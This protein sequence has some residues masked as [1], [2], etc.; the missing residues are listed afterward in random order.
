MDAR[1][2][3]LSGPYAGQTI[4]IPNG[5]LIVG[6]EEDCHLR[7]Q[8][9]SVSR[10]HCVL[11]LDGYVL[12]IRDLGSRNGTFLNNRPVDMTGTTISS[13][14]IVSIGDMVCQIELL[15]VASPE[16][17]PATSPA[18]LQGIVFFDGKLVQADDPTVGQQ[19][20]SPPS[21]IPQPSVP[22]PPLASDDMRK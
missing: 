13:G 3:V 14:D 21:T 20:P 7:P 4:E 16:A 5:Q 2:N 9:R 1:L 18:S 12:R 6:R 11:F 10:H 8:S 19:P 17:S 22:N 15:E